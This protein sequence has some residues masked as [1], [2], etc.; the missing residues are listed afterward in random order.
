MAISGFGRWAKRLVLL[1]GIAV[2]PD[3]PIS[4]L[5]AQDYRPD[6]FDTARVVG[7]EQCQKCHAEQVAVLQQHAH[8]QSGRQFH[9]RDDAK[10]M[11]KKLGY[12][13]VKRSASCMQCHYTPAKDGVRTKAISGVSCESCHGP[14]RDWLH[15]HNN[16]GGLNITR[17]AESKEHRQQRLSTAMARGMNPPSHLYALARSCVRC[18]V[19]NDERLVNEGG[20][21][22][23]SKGFDFVAWSQG[24]VRHNFIRGEGRRNEPSDR[25]RLRVMY[26]VGLLADLEASLRSAAVATAKAEF[27]FAHALRASELR[28]S[29]KEIAQLTGD[30]NLEK[31]AAVAG[32]AKLS[33]GNR[34][35]LETAADAI[36]K[37]AWL[38]ANEID[39]EQ[40]EAIDPLIPATESFIGQPVA[41]P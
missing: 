12:S 25:N 18:H 36:S 34:V 10:A 26:V 21:P 20:H 38:F 23:R 5:A 8:Y 24:N 35:E 17:E 29:A 3:G 22:A 16:Y 11:A 2:C 27:G 41:R 37:A 15:V 40:L 33:L 4:K 32:Q 7:Y 9:R 39:G 13:S 30:E 14:A 31:A 28:D 19:I 6:G 1:F